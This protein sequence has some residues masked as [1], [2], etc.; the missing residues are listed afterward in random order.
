MDNQQLKELFYSEEMESIRQAYYNEAYKQGEFD[1]AARKGHTKEVFSWDGD[2]YSVWKDRVWYSDKDQ[3]HIE[4]E[5]Y[6]GFAKLSHA[7]H[8]YEKFNAEFKKYIEQHGE[9]KERNDSGWKQVYKTN[10]ID[11]SFE[12]DSYWIFLDGHKSEEIS[13]LYW[14]MHDVINQL[15]ELNDSL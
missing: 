6:M 13:D 3:F 1:E 15:K 11:I 9:L 10:A 2:D 12:G 5:G 7:I 14:Y 4:V 8:S